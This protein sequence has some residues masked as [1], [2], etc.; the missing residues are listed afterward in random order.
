MRY[1]L[2]YYVYI[3]SFYDYAVRDKR[4]QEAYNQLEK[5]IKDNKL[6][7]ENLHKAWTEFDFAKK[8]QVSE[9]GTKR[10]KEIKNNVKSFPLGNKAKKN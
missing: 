4:F 9:I 1:N 10:W 2:F 8:G 7:P 6:I 3:L 5:K